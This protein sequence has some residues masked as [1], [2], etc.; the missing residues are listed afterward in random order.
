LE[1]V[2]DAVARPV[3]VTVTFAVAVVVP[4]G[5]YC[6]LIVQLFPVPT[7]STVVLVQVPPAMIEKV[8]PAVP[9]FVIVGAAVNVNGPA[10][11]PVA[12]LVTVTKPLCVVVVP[13]TNDGFGPE[14]AT[15]APVT[16]NPF[17]SAG[18]VPMGVV[19]VTFLAP[20]PAPAVI[21]QFALTVVAVDVMPV[22]VTP[23]P[24]MATAVAPVRLV[25]VSVTGTVVPRLPLTGEMEVNVGP[26]TVN[27]TAL[28]TPAG[29]VTVTFLAPVAAPVVMVKVAVTVVSFT[30]L[31]ALTVT[32]PPDTVTAV[33]PV[34]PTPVMVT[35]T[36]VPRTPVL[37]AI[38]ASPV[39]TPLIVTTAGLAGSL[40]ATLS[41]P[42]CGPSA[43][44]A[45]RTL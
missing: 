45:N 8:P 29:V 5:T 30:A 28:V 35:G 34:R 18:V 23:P 27:V 37:G 39:P 44:G 7:L 31:K 26:C 3:P 12:V 19:T 24:A 14:N 38:E 9:T 10:L 33:A 43:V 6:T 42:A 16:V 36:A 21:A 20:S 32:P 41:V 40:E 4:D 22:Q 25:P 17:V 15:V 2:C 13:V 11:A 1:L